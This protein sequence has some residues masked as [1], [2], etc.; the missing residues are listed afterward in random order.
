[1]NLGIPKI[2]GIMFFIPG[3]GVTLLVGDCLKTR[4]LAEVR[5]YPLVAAGV[6]VLEVLTILGLVHLMKICKRQKPLTIGE[7]PA[8]IMDKNPR[9][10]LNDRLVFLTSATMHL[11]GLVCGFWLA[12][13]RYR[14]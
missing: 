10:Q 8:R 1:M 9:Q 5:S 11:L 14:P 2:M 12:W 4:S 13:T 3:F 7:L 6:L